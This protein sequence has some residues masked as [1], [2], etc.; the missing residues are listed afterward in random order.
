MRC[1]QCHSEN[2]EIRIV[3]IENKKV[4]SP[5]LR[6]VLVLAWIAAIVAVGVIAYT[7][8]TNQINTENIEE[9]IATLLANSIELIISWKVFVGS[10]IAIVACSLYIKLL[11]YK[12]IPVRKAICKQ[13]G[14]EQDIVD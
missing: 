14:L 7:L 13:C 4:S 2:F 12:V 5:F 8:F 1:K 3:D 9:A 11:P 6:F 10:V